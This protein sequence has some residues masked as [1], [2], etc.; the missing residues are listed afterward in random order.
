MSR[1]SNDTTV[2]TIGHSNASFN[3]IARLLQKYSI[4]VLVDVRSRPRSRWVPHF[5]RANLAV[6]IP[7]LGIE[8][9]YAGNHLGGLP[10]DP[11]YYKPN[12]QRKRRTDPLTVVDYDKVAR[13]NWFHKATDELLEVASHQRTAIM[14]SEENPHE[15]H[16]SRLVGRALVK[17]GVKVLHI[18]GNGDIEPQSSG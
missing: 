3:K 9:Q 15:C 1:A 13:Q 5:N 2:Y 6:A 12:P 18:R 8:Y 7:K 10:D 14:C 11:A 17:K 4:Q 16:R